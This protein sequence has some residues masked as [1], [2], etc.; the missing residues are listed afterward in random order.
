MVGMVSSEDRVCRVADRARR[1]SV[2]L[3]Q[4]IYVGVAMIGLVVTPLMSLLWAPVLGVSVAALFASFVCYCDPRWYA[5]R[6][7][8]TITVVTAG[9]VPFVG[10]LALLGGVGRAVAL[11]FFLVLAVAVMSSVHALNRGPTTAEGRVVAHDLGVLVQALSSVPLDDLFRHWQASQ[12][13]SL[14]GDH[15]VSARVAALRA[16]VLDE[17]ER[18]DPEGFSRWLQEGAAEAPDRFIRGDRGLAA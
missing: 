3:L 14:T 13:R 17:L 10:G 2:P 7:L 1:I 18:R 8:V 16:A 4:A 15:E 12:G 6:I 11:V 9:A 5:P